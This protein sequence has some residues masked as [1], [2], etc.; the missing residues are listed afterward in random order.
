M[1][2]RRRGAGDAQHANRRAGSTRG[3]PV[4]VAIICGSLNR[5]RKVSHKKVRTFCTT[6]IDCWPLARESPQVGHFFPGSIY[7]GFSMETRFG[8][9]GRGC[10]KS[11]QNPTK[12]IRLAAHVSPPERR[13]RQAA[14]QPPCGIDQGHAC[15]RRSHL[16]ESESQ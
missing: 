12:E 2:H 9:M 16:W 14:R 10:L 15:G 13:W 6:S 3:M 7:L 4:V 5:N 8:K 1:Y 11:A